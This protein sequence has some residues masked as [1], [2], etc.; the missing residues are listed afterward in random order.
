MIDRIT[1]AISRRT[2]F[3]QTFGTPHGKRVLAYLL[4]Q[5]KANATVFH[6]HNERQNA[7]QQ[8]RQSVGYAILDWLNLSDEQ[9][10]TLKKS[11]EYNND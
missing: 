9:I 2:D 10:E 4:R 11:K 5:T 1:A 7:F 8:G 3:R 6:A